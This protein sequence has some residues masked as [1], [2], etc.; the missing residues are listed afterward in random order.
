[1]R[2][3]KDNNDCLCLRVAKLHIKLRYFIFLFLSLLIT[4]NQQFGTRNDS[5]DGGGRGKNEQ[6]YGYQLMCIGK[7]RYNN[8]GRRVSKQRTRKFR[9]V[10]FRETTKLSWVSSVIIIKLL[11]IKQLIA[12]VQFI[13]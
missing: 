4:L 10:G 13:T 12:K 8:L 6:N 1:M 7:Q 9:R 5:N 11:K 3:S 2:L